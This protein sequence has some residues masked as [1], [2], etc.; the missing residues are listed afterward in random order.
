MVSAGV[1]L[2]RQDVKSAYRHPHTHTNLH[3]YQPQ[4]NVSKRRQ[5]P[6][7]QTWHGIPFVEQVR[8]HFSF[9]LSCFVSS[10]AVVITLQLWQTAGGGWW[11]E[12][13]VCCTFSCRGLLSGSVSCNCQWRRWKREDVSPQA[14]NLL[15]LLN[16][17]YSPLLF[18]QRGGAHY[19]IYVILLCQMGDSGKLARETARRY[20]RFWL[21]QKN[22]VG[23]HKLHM[24]PGNC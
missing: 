21:K 20:W 8:C 13:G 10:R 4:S 7:T 19:T 6:E 5:R 24:C 11:G 14:L 12:D 1:F 17:S 9:A 22:V 16:H 15:C 18:P 3:F 23:V 2:Q